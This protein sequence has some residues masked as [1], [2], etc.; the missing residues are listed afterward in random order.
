MFLLSMDCTGCDTIHDGQMAPFCQSACTNTQIHT[1]HL[2]CE[3]AV[4]FRK[5]VLILCVSGSYSSILHFIV[6]LGAA[7]RGLL[8]A[9]PVVGRRLSAN[10]FSS[11]G[12]VR[13]FGCS[14]VVT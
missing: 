2:T 13:R 1:L 5:L 12:L 11:R 8:G 14:I 9:G 7:G 6:G 10:H 4:H 3:A